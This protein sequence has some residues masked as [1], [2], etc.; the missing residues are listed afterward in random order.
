M[1]ARKG[2]WG[3]ARGPGDSDWSRQR[4][5]IPVIVPAVIDHEPSLCLTR[6]STPRGL[7][8]GRR[9]AELAITLVML[10]VAVACSPLPGHP[11]PVAPDA[12]QWARESR[13]IAHALGG[14][15]TLAYT[16]SLEA[17]TTNYARGLRVFEVDLV[18]ARDGQL[19]ALHD[20]SPDLLRVLG[21]AI[22]PGAE[23]PL[24]SA[25]FLQSRIHGR[26]TPLGVRDLLGLLRSHPDA[27][28]VTDTKVTEGPGM[29]RPFEALVAAAREVDPTVLDRV[30][31]Q[32]YNQAMLGA[33]RAVYPFRSW[34]YTL[35]LS[36]DTDAQVVEF[37]RRSWVRCVTL[38]P[39][40]VKPAFLADLKAA[41]VFT[42]VHTINTMDEVRKLEAAGVY[43]FYTDTLAPGDL[44]PPTRGR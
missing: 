20:W 11:T 15:G 18:F 36:K 35:Y 10:G 16:N 13:L 32:I 40:R 25:Q 38:A 9:K 8:A 5:E 43:G 23:L 17:F 19:V 39:Y 24:G 22:P 2:Q 44:A 7:G 14:I 31:P 3:G 42:F 41:G 34:I 6:F 4:G 21:I 29:T 1:S 37:V 30:I 28:L 27:W 33:V 12:Y 26:L